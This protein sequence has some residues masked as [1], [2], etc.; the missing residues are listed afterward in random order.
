MPSHGRTP[1]LRS[2]MSERAR[3]VLPARRI[4][5]L[6]TD[7]QDS[8]QL[9]DQS[10]A[11]MRQA[12]ARHDVLIEHCVQ[13]HGGV[14]VR[15]RGEGDSRFAV[16][17]SASNAVSAALE[18]QRLVLREPWPTAMPLRLHLAVHTG[19]AERRDGDYYGSDVNRCARLRGLAHGGQI[20]VSD[21]TARLTQS[22]LPLG[23]TLEYL[24]EYRLRGLKTP[25]RV[26]Q[27]KH[28][29]L[30]AGFPPLIGG[31]PEEG[32]TPFLPAYPF[33]APNR[34]VGRDAELALF[35]EIL[36][37]GRTQAEV[38]FVGAAAGTGKS[39]LLGAVVH[40]AR[41]AGFTCLAGGCYESEAMIPLR[42]LR[43]GLV[44]YVLSFPAEVIRAELGGT[45]VE[46][47]DF[48]PELRHHLGLPER[49]PAQPAADLSRVFGL[50]HTVLRCLAERS[51]VLLCFEDLHV[52]DV[53]SLD[54]IQFLVRQARRLPVVLVGTYRSDEVRPGDRLAQ[55]LAFLEREGAH[56]I[57]LE[58][59]SR[60][61]TARVAE[62]VLGQPI[63]DGLNERIFATTDGT[64]FFV[65]QLVLA[66][67]EEE[68]IGVRGGIWQPV[69]DTAGVLPP[70]A[71]E[72][73]QRRLERLSQ[74]SR[75]TLAMAAVLGQSVEHGTLLATCESAHDAD[76]LDSLDEA[77]EAGILTETASGYAFGH[78]LLRETVYWGLT[79]PRRMLLH[80]RAGQAIERLAA[81]RNV[82]RSA[83]L[84]HHFCLGGS[85]PVIRAKALRYSMHAGTNAESLS[86][87]RD[88]LTHFTNALAI[89]EDQDFAVE[90]AVRLAALHGRGQAERNLGH[91]TACVATFQLLVDQT[92]DAVQ[93]A[94]SYEAIGRARAQMGDTPG[95]RSAYEAG[96]A[97]LASSSGDGAEAVRLQLL[98]DQAFCDFI[99]GRYIHA[100]ELGA[101]VLERAVQ[102]GRPG[103]LYRAHSVLALAWMHQGQFVPAREHYS[104]ALTVAEQ[105]GD[106]MLLAVVHENMGAQAYLSGDFG[107]ARTRLARSIE[108]YRESVSD[109]R[110]VLAL[111]LLG[112]VNLAEGDLDQAFKTVQ[113]ADALAMDGGDRWRAECDQV[114]GAVLA[115]RGEWEGASDRLQQA[116]TTYERAEHTVGVCATLC[117]L[118]S[119]HEQ[120]GHWNESE[121]Y[122]RKSA[123]A[124]AQLDTCPT[125]V[126][127]KRQLGRFLLRRGAISEASSLIEDVLALAESMPLSLEY[128]PSLLAKAELLAADD[129]AAAINY[130]E[131]PLHEARTLE[132]LLETHLFLAMAY[133]AAGQPHRALDHAEGATALADRTGSPWLS[134]Q[135]LR[136]KT[137]VQA[138]LG[139]APDH[140]G[141]ATQHGAS[142]V[143][144]LA[145]LESATN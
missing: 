8:V 68:R 49:P 136:V 98:Y 104:A 19:T 63:S 139:P 75:Q 71:R 36:A 17:N 31:T 121:R 101:E 143:A 133:F 108:L 43:D 132:T 30:P 59:L 56:R 138:R 88:A 77:L 90:E 13:E 66:L 20:L 103:P 54:L 45:V 107:E 27:L 22:H 95:A 61:D 40:R 96:L 5:F 93:R 62:S 44:D 94:T 16:F 81:V 3:R 29:E 72:V 134:Q 129:L 55:L 37:H 64:P 48:I 145:P 21:Q 18:I 10:A 92:S 124:A 12:L 142:S 109:V 130:A 2:S 87:H 125:V 102:L 69:A 106:K 86:A 97:A 123:R 141:L 127:A 42:P 140:G 79:A 137:T 105:T 60:E 38:A 67:R 28:S 128:A 7:V 114:L 32:R 70:I 47:A 84:A 135:V 82:D 131:K 78:A 115:M 23:A 91:W 122:Y 41:H 6:L 118:G 57:D 46:L 112:N 80:A 52:A 89:I 15:P 9:W 144:V 26:Y 110:A 4:T 83:E 33:P 11:T 111:Q 117:A 113:Q 73:I 14:I 119:I 74:R 99:K 34:L 120:R 39:T 116:L 126:R 50:L 53:T 76:L 1:L 25:E 58:A 85:D 24:G 65:E 35:D 51:P 100:R